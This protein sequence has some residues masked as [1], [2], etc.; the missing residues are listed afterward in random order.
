[1]SAMGKRLE[2]NETCY[3]LTNSSLMF[4]RIKTSLGQRKN[5]FFF[6]LYIP[7]GTKII[8]YIINRYSKIFVELHW[9]EI[10]IILNVCALNLETFICFLP[11]CFSSGMYSR[12]LRSAQSLCLIHI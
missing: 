9:N 12:F 3:V 5:R 4:I 11:T 7:H 1:M 8:L 2:N 6:P 10:Y